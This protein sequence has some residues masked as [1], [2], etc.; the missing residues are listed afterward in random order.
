MTLFFSIE[1][2]TSDAGHH[3]EHLFMSIAYRKGK[4]SSLG[5][6]AKLLS[7]LK[8]QI[9]QANSVFSPLIISLAV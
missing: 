3:N 9:L 1:K 6:Q 2:S 4:K 7:M 5:A 8:G